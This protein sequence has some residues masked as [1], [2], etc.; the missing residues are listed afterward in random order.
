MP[1]FIKSSRFN[2]TSKDSVHPLIRC[3][4]LGVAQTV[5][6]PDSGSFTYATAEGG[7]EVG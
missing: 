4:H 2:Y 7:N 5:G 1:A 6:L 3:H